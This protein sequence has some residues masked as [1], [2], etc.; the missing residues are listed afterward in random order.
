MV[1]IVLPL[2]DFGVRPEHYNELER[3]L[4]DMSR[5]SVTFPQRSALTNAELSATGGLCHVAI[6]RKNKRRQNAHF[7]FHEQIVHTIINPQNGFSQILKET[8]EKASSI[9]TAKLY[10]NICYLFGTEIYFKC[11]SNK[12]QFVS[13]FSETDTE[14]Q[15]RCLNAQNQLLVHILR[16]VSPAFED[17]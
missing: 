8:V 15:R 2:R 12:I 4:L 6:E 3:A 7:F 13:R 17:S 10:F 5:I 11:R 16:A 1:E 9:Y 14:K